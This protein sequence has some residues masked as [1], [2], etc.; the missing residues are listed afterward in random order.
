MNESFPNP[1]Y[2]IYEISVE[3]VRDKI[4][5]GY[6]LIYEDSYGRG[7]LAPCFSCK[8]QILRPGEAKTRRIGGYSEGLRVWLDEVRFAED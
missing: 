6:A 4:V 1:K 5:Q 7:F 2:H 8:D 3:N